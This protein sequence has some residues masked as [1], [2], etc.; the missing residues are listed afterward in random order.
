MPLTSTGYSPRRFPQIREVTR[1]SLESNLGTNISSSPDSVVGLA[2]TAFANQQA[3]VENEAQA[4]YSQLNVDTAEST[5]LD[6]L[7]AW[8]GIRRLPAAPAIGSLL[9]FRNGEGTIESS[10]RFSDGG[11]RSVITPNGLQHSLTE[12]NA[13]T[14]EPTNVVVGNTYVITIND[15]VFTYVPQTGDTAVDICDQFA[16]FIGTAYS[17]ITTQSSGGSLQIKADDSVQNFMS[18]TLT[19]FTLLEIGTYNYAE[20]VVRGNV[21]VTANTITTISSPNPTLLSV[22]N[23]LEFL[24]GREVET[25]EELR[26]RHAVSTQAASVATVPAI[27]GRILNLPNVASASIQENTSWAVDADGRPPKSYEV[28]VEGG[29]PLQIAQNIWESKPAGAETY[30][31][32]TTQVVDAFDNTVFVNWS[33]PESVYVHIE[34]TYSK[35]NEEPFPINGENAILLSVVDYM[36]KLGLGKDVIPTRIIGQIYRSVSGIGDISIRVGVATNAGALQPDVWQTTN[37]PIAN[38]QF[39]DVTAGRVAIIEVA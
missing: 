3:R 7:V 12:C 19:G 6:K 34:V 31:S 9:V 18:I 37:I 26:A 39:A 28:V 23:P 16:F 21:S 22:N 14:V 10:I 35:Y 25:D 11:N 5:Y 32:I 20:S 4:L 27:T 17:D 13:V 38:N 30:G 29:D 8:V 33:R 15:G 1:E 24:D 2:L 36:D